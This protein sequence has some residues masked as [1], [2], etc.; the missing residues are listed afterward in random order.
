MKKSKQIF[1]LI[2][3]LVVI[4]I[5]AILAGMLLPALNKA[6]SSS[7]AADCRSQ[8]KNIGLAY[9]SYMSDY[10]DWT[11]PYYQPGNTEQTS[12]MEDG[13]PMILLKNYLNQPNVFTSKFSNCPAL[14][15]RVMKGYNNISSGTW[16][17]YG[18]NIYSARR[19]AGK[20]KAASMRAT[21]FDHLPAAWASYGNFTSTTILSNT[22]IQV[23][24]G[25][26]NSAFLDGH[27]E[28]FI[29]HQFFWLS[30]GDYTNLKYWNK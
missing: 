28:H 12:N 21:V 30:D 17:T 24:S 19:K 22:W 1:T 5:I 2:E 4:A 23:H 15:S 3:L 27:A 9:N 14:R 7:L 8:L 11:P 29:R 25:G 16:I 6:R 10:D 13:T 26:V 18:Y 20:V